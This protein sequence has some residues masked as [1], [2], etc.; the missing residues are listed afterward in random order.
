MLYK[1]EPLEP[2]EAGC[3]VDVWNPFQTQV[4]PVL[5]CSVDMALVTTAMRLPRIF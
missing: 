3:S 4:K 1:S 5:M 2:D